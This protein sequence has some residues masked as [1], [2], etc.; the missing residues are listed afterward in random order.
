M[1]QR[2]YT[3][4]LSFDFGEILRPSFNISGARSAQLSPDGWDQFLAGQENELLTLNNAEL[5]SRIASD[6]VAQVAA[7]RRQYSDLNK[8]LSLTPRSL[9]A[10]S[11]EA[12]SWAIITLAAVLIVIV[13]M[14][15]VVGN[16]VL[17]SYV[18]ASASPLFANSPI[19]A[20]LF[21][22][23]PSFAAVALQQFEARLTSAT[24]KWH[25]RNFIFAAGCAGFALYL[26]CTAVTFAPSAGD[27][28]D[29]LT[30]GQAG[31]WAPVALVLSTIVAE[32]CFGS[33]ILQRI[34]HLLSISTTASVPN[35]EF[36]AATREKLRLERQI[37]RA[38]HEHMRAKDY[39]SRLAA[40]R[41]VT[42]GE[43][44]QE[45]AKARELWLQL[46]TAALAFAIAI[47]LSTPEETD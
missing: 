14:G 9:T 38:K 11:K 22:T 37:A 40:A 26:A 8:H 33:T 5:A 6:L 19:H 17:S 34:S 25:L 24:V 29:L 12:A 2:A 43:A 35:P 39:L 1:S 36:A 23:M 21:A 44:L 45:L 47:F 10:P 16:V 3:R 4:P 31:Q 46:Q 7:F 30:G 32:I 13:L 20:M 27:A 42:R 41:E 28:L 18:L 15:M